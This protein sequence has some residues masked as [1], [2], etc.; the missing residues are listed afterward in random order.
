MNAYMHIRIYAPLGGDGLIIKSNVKENKITS[1]FSNTT[2]YI[3][4]GRDGGNISDF[5]WILWEYWFASFSP[6][7]SEQF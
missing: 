2:L 3:H 1:L 6:Y 5:C 4:L 7:L